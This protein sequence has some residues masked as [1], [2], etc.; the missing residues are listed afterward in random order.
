M[1]D[2]PNIATASPPH[3]PASPVPAEYDVFCESCGYSLV[4][5]TA[6]RCPEC[7]TAYDPN[8]LPFARVPW[9]HRRRLGAVRAYLATVRMVIFSPRRFAR[10][11]CRPVRVSADDAKRF[12]KMTLR[13]ATASFLLSLIGIAVADLP[14][15]ALGAPFI[16]QIALAMLAYAVGAAAFFAL[17]TDMPL[18]IWKGLPARPPSELAPVHHYAAA[19]LALMPLVGAAAV[20]GAFS[21]Q[22]TEMA[23][24]ADGVGVLVLFGAAGVVF[25]VLWV[26]S[27][28]LMKSASGARGGRLLALALY[29]PFHWL[30]VLLLVAL[31]MGLFA[32]VIVRPL[33]SYLFAWN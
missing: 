15:W 27:L 16:V 23:G 25:F 28:V 18:F 30:L 13:I 12:R 33:L 1:T 31:S 5:I 29:L 14:G 3:D 21:A 24:D 9:L 20:A 4:G 10:E 26:L 17:A 22:F 7:G 11:L 2:V 6:D 19:P 8:E 32:M